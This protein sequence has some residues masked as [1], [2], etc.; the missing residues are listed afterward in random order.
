MVR[1]RTTLGS[2][3]ILAALSPFRVISAVLTAGRSLPVYPQLRTWPCTR[4]LTLCARLGSSRFLRRYCPP[5]AKVAQEPALSL[6][7][8]GAD[9]TAKPTREAEITARGK[10]DR[11]HR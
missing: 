9:T 1:N 6:F 3:R 11:L 5:R 8:S 4:K 2:S 10:N 7:S